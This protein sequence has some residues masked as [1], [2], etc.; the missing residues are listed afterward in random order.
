LKEGTFIDWPPA[1]LPARRAYRPE[2][3][4]YP[5]GGKKKP[6]TRTYEINSNFLRSYI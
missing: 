1:P 4:A 5:P 2:G 6:E 3:R